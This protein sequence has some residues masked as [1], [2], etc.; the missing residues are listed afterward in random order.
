MLL[1]VSTPLFLIFVSG[2]YSIRLPTLTSK[3]FTENFIS[4]NFETAVL[5]QRMP[6][7]TRHL[8]LLLYVRVCVC[9]YRVCLTE[10]M[11][12]Q[13]INSSRVVL[14]QF[15]SLCF[16]SRWEGINFAWFY[17]SFKDFKI[18]FIAELCT[19]DVLTLF[20]QVRF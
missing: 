20:F 12:R 10:F 7:C 3:L 19:L 2:L 15:K 6:A 5:F 14:L 17:G 13:T 16:F 1:K 9:I 4:P 8:S 18:V 11:L